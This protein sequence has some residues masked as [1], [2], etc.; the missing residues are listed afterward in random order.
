MKFIKFL[1]IF[2]FSFSFYKLTF[3]LLSVRNSQAINNAL[4]GLVNDLSNIGFPYE[5]TLSGTIISIILCIPTSIAIHF[6][7]KN[8]FRED[9]NELF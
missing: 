8:L 3:Y 5:F 9:L 1:I 4:L 7:I 6:L 2:I